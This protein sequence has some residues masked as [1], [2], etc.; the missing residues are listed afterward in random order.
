MKH[1]LEDIYQ[2]VQIHALWSKL[3]PPQGVIDFPIYICQALRIVEHAVPP[4]AL[5]LVIMHGYRH[6]KCKSLL[7]ALGHLKSLCLSVPVEMLMFEKDDL[8]AIK[9]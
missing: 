1:L 4:T 3:A 8:P 5:V 2:F 6:K 9:N 7:E